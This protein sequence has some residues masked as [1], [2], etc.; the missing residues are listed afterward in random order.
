MRKQ[1]V[2]TR[3]FNMYSYNCFDTFVIKKNQIKKHV[4][5]CV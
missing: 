2:W 3:N 1:G 4:L 5:T